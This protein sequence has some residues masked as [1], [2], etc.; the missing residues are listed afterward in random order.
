MTTLTIKETHVSHS[1]RKA[2]CNPGDKVKLIAEH[3]DVVIVELKG[4]R[5]SIPKCK[6]K[7]YAEHDNR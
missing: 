5:F 6:I 7:E 2:L 3:G 1:K 4:T